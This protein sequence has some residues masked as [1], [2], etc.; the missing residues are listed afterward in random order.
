MTSLCET[1]D[2]SL[3]VVILHPRATLPASAHVDDAGYDVMMPGMVVDYSVCIV[4]LGIAVEAPPGTYIQIAGRSSLAAK[5]VQPLGGVVDRGYSGEISVLLH[6]H[7]DERLKLE[8]GDQ[9]A[10]LLVLHIAK[11]RP[12]HVKELQASA[13][14]LQGF[15]STG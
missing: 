10:Q 3:R 5:G 15:G 4:P 6:N 7:N 13:R 8:A 14:G 12:L 9:I 2:Q 11:P 1:D